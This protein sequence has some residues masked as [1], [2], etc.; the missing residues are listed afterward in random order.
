[1]ARIRS[2]KPEFWTN[3]KIVDC[4]TSAR[5]L[6]IG[7]W[8]FSDDA[9]VHP[10]S[11]RRIKMQV[12]P[13]DDITSEQ[14]DQYIEE[15]I[16]GKLLREFSEN[17]E[18]YWHIV[19][20][21]EHQK[22][23]RPTYKYPKPPGWIAPQQKKSPNDRKQVV[24]DSSSDRRGLVERLPPDGIGEETKGKEGSLSG[25]VEVFGEIH[26][27]ETLN[28]EE[29]NEI[30]RWV[31]S[32]SDEP[33]F[34]PGSPQLAEKIMQASRYKNQGHS[35]L[36]LVSAAIAG[37]YKQL[38][39]GRKS[40]EAANTDYEQ[41]PEW[42]AILQIMREHGRDEM[43]DDVEWRSKNMTKAQKKAKLEA[44]SSWEELERANRFDRKNIAKDYVLAFERLQAQGVPHK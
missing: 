12:F 3:E 23:D 30:A 37:G 39:P 5:L 14:V 13:G 21:N 17:G 35:I 8:T 20:F 33:T 28:S 27:P 6:F 22:I 34:F 2:I 44:F 1:M 10:A 29:L 43:T 40:S 31:R 38:Y 32:M 42:L 15:L 24:E 26:L 7:L 18:K 11:A 41:H 19:G 4:S 25:L 16:R 9:G 36:D